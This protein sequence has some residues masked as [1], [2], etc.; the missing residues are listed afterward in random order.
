ME[1]L[2]KKLT[3]PVVERMSYLYE[4]LRQLEERPQLRVTSRELGALTGQMPTTV[5]KDIHFVGYN[6]SV[7][8]RYDVR[9]LRQTIAVRLGFTEAKEACI[10]GLG[11]LGSALLNHF[12]ASQEPDL[13]IVAGFDSNVNRLETIRTTIELYPAYRIEEIIARKKIA[14][15][16]IAVPA[17]SA[18]E[19]VD[20]CCAGGVSGILNF[21]P[22]RVV[23]KRKDV[24]LRSFDMTSELRILSARSFLSV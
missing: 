6:G 2:I 12:A 22:V 1:Q 9:E 13:Q 7:G 8:A 24:S 20:R 16:I 19:V 3:D 14:L 5:R 21:S 4:V 11:A 23:L 18:Q 17:T 15:A 10:V